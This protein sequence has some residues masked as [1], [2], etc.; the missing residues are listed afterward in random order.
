[1][2]TYLNAEI[3]DHKK[4]YHLA[5]RVDVAHQH[6]T[7]SNHT[8]AGIRKLEKCIFLPSGTLMGG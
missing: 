1:M 6:V 8:K 2:D 4:S 3:R 5:S 7:F